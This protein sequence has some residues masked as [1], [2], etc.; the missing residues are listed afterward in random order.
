MGAQIWVQRAEKA[1]TSSEQTSLRIVCLS[2][3][4]VEQNIF[5]P[6]P[7]RYFSRE[8]LLFV[9][10]FILPEDAGYLLGPKSRGK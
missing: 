9:T 10:T 7:M 8:E 5:H 2:L 4:K 1:L 6:R 3:S